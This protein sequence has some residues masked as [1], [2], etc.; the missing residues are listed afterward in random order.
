MTTTAATAAT[1]TAATT[2][3]PYRTTIHRDGTVTYWSVYQQQWQRASAAALSDA[4]LASLGARD[5]ARVARALARAA[6]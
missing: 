3:D 4:T 6:M 5:R 1:T 2:T